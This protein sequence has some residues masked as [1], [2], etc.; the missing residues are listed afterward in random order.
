[1][2]TRGGPLKNLLSLNALGNSVGSDLTAVV[3]TLYFPKRGHEIISFF[4]KS[5]KAPVRFR[6]FSDFASDPLGAITRHFP[7][8][9]GGKP[10][11]KIVVGLGSMDTVR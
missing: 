8:L 1:M 7:D 5:V 4:G 9:F 11:V 3:G 6:S 10:R 2:W